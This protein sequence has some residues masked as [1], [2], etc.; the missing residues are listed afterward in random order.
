MESGWST[1][2]VGA[3]IVVFVQC[4]A[5]V[6]DVTTVHRFD[7]PFPDKHDQEFRNFRTIGERGTTEIHAMTNARGLPIRLPNNTTIS[8]Y[9]GV[10]MEELIPMDGGCNW[11]I[12]TGDWRNVSLATKEFPPLQLSEKSFMVYTFNNIST[13][14]MFPNKLNFKLKASG[15]FSS[16]YI[17]IFLMASNPNVLVGDMYY[18]Q[19]QMYNSP[20]HYGYNRGEMYIQ[21]LKLSKCTS[22]YGDYVTIHDNQR[23][24]CKSIIDNGLSLP[25]TDFCDYEIQ[26]S[27][28]VLTLTSDC[29]SNKLLHWEDSNPLDIVYYR[30]GSTGITGEFHVHTEGPYALSLR[31][32]EGSLTS[33][34]FVP[35]SNT[36]CVS[37]TYYL[38][39]TAGNS[40]HLSIHWPG[41]DKQ[42]FDS[43]KAMGEWKTVRLTATITTAKLNEKVTVELKGRKSKNSTV[44]IQRIAGCNGEGFEDILVLSDGDAVNIQNIG[45]DVAV[46]Q[47]GNKNS[48]MS[49][50]NGGIFDTEY[51]S[52]VCPA[53]FT[54]STCEK[55]CGANRYGA[56]CEALCS[57]TKDYCQ[58]MVLCRPKLGCNCASGLKGILCN[59]YCDF[60]E[61]GAGCKQKC[62]QCANMSDCDKYTGECPLGCDTGYYPPFCQETYRY[63]SVPPAVSAV[64]VQ[65][66]KVTADLNDSRGKGTATFYQLQYKENLGVNNLWQEV[67]PLPV[68]SYE[69]S[70]N[71]TGLKS[72]ID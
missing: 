11:N 9:V 41:G 47:S 38:P 69:L 70:G 13:Y 30:F 68:L 63:L 64:T 52:C 8:F 33:P 22:G 45:Y 50:A 14:H 67:E 20:H 49:C 19:L 25:Y 17:E 3:F 65:G 36:L 39:L 37:L 54:G 72:G 66:F 46:V 5:E 58:R 12:S 26:F 55:G 59:T 34:A 44:F 4:V 56:S 2:F 48:K 23:S 6:Y 61:Y 32:E 29:Q 31:S 18:I 27:A 7:L 28:G 62:G 10:N 51:G 40:L 16:A 71:V 60:G 43:I 53:G 35:S 24:G 57:K 21:S 42:D 15:I 1:L